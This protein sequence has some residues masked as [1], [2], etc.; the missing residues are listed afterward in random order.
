MTTP[1]DN[2]TDNVS[3]ELTEKFSVLVINEFNLQEYFEK[4]IELLYSIG[5]F[6][7]VKRNF[8]NHQTNWC[9]PRLPSLCHQPQTT[10]PYILLLILAM[11][12]LELHHLL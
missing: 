12:E 4:I 3:T 9:H 7:I 6:G 11:V 10:C 8:S 5:K 2:L 1:E